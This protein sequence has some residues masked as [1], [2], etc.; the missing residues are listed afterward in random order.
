MS[1]SYAER[2]RPAAPDGGATGASA[3]GVTSPGVRSGALLALFEFDSLLFKV[4][5]KLG[6][7]H[8]TIRGQQDV[9]I[10]Q[11]T[12]VCARSRRLQV[13]RISQSDADILVKASLAKSSPDFG[14]ARNAKTVDLTPRKIK[15]LRQ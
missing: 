10:T 12:I 4:C 7:G 8:S 5:C 3:A 14:N 1:F 2:Q 6:D 15:R 11:P 13:A 9:V